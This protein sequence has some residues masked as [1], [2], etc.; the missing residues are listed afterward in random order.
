M[1]IK[2]DL[3]S[4]CDHLP[5]CLVP[6]RHNVDATLGMYDVIAHYLGSSLLVPAPGPPV[7]CPT[8]GPVEEDGDT[9]IPAHL[10]LVGQ[11]NNTLAP[12]AISFV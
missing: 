1:E 8:H 2:Y 5:A 4:P 7:P 12:F 10:K 11:A 6:F 3:A 9:V